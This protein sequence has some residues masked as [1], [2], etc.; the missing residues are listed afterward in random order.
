MIIDG[1]TI[2]LKETSQGNHD[3]KSDGTITYTRTLCFEG[4]GD[5]LTLEVKGIKYNKIYNKTIDIYQ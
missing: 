1:K 3:K 2:E 4:S 5:K